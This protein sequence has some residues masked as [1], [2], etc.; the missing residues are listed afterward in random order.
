MKAGGDLSKSKVVGAIASEEIL[1]P[2]RGRGSAFID[3]D[4]KDGFSIRNFQIQTVKMALVSDVIVYR[5]K[6]T[7]MSAAT[8]LAKRIAE[9]Q[10]TWK[11]SNESV[12]QGPL[13]FN[14]F[15]VSSE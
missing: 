14:T 15:V 6:D 5:D 2:L 10:E 3:M 1:S 4:P 13:S 7:G 11:E 12:I 8:N 9:A